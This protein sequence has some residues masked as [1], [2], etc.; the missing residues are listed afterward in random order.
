MDWIVLSR[1]LVRWR[2]TFICGNEPLGSIKCW[3]FLDW[4][5]T[6]LDFKKD[7][8]PWSKKVN[9]EVSK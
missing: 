8:A 3:E 4:L 5:R 2:V 6:G 7:S 1:D 9:K